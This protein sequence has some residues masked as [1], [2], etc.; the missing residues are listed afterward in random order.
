MLLVLR[1]YLCW[2]SST[3][4]FCTPV[5]RNVMW[6]L[7]KFNSDCA[8]TFILTFVEIWVDS[9]P[10]SLKANSLTLELDYRKNN[11][12]FFSQSLK[13]HFPTTSEAQCLVKFW[14]TTQTFNWLIAFQLNYHRIRIYCNSITSLYPTPHTNVTI[15]FYLSRWHFYYEGVIRVGFLYAFVYG[16]IV[17]D[18]R[19]WV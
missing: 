3:A 5:S 2:Y 18:S 11:F 1:T 17:V 7:Y 15:H 13:H 19:C 16:T 8:T 14:M 10:Q 9:N 4:S 12:R 6:K